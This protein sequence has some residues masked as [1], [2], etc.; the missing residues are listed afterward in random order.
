MNSQDKHINKFLR[1]PLPDPEIP[2]DDAWAGMN[3][4][5]NVPADTNPAGYAGQGQLAGVWK[6][7][8]KFKGLLIGISAIITLAVIALIVMNADTS[9]SIQVKTGM[10]TPVPGLKKEDI[11][12]F[13]GAS[14][15]LP[16]ATTPAGKTTSGNALTQIAPSRTSP[17]EKTPAATATA[18]VS[19][20]TKSG[21]PA[22]SG[23]ERIETDFI[24]STKADDKLRRPDTR[25]DNTPRTR[26]AYAPVSERGDENHPILGVENPSN[27]PALSFPGSLKPLTGH[28]ESTQADLSNLVQKPASPNPTPATA[29]MRSSMWKN[30]H[31]GPEWTV[32]RSIVSTKYMFAGADSVN[33]P[34]RL[35]IP[36]LF[37]SKSW[38]RHSATF[39][40]NPLHSYVGEK[41]RIAQ[42][43]DTTRLTDSLYDIAIHNTYF[44]KS[45]GVNFALQ[46]QFEAARWLSLVGGLSYAHYPAALLRKEIQTAGNISQAYEKA[47]GRDAMQTYLRAQQ[48]NIRVGF[49][50]GTPDVLNGRLQIGF[51]MIIPVSNLAQDGI[52]SIKSPNVQGS[53]RF[54][55]K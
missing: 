30:I 17:A 39:I 13:G 28:F 9:N 37:V 11:P 46:Y 20:A 14:Q 15:K 33:H 34:W 51:T 12:A 21:R 23:N 3:D 45:F 5:L 27:A 38:K 55:V 10:K 29:K 52:K 31:F 41:E 35:A 1:D 36:G 8:A 32:N 40:F 42:R 44:I 26:S 47:R 4:M 54:L 24:R 18:S 25:R 6:A 2:A 22:G 50:S 16:A 49:L 43:V 53:I 19:P 7:A 48:W